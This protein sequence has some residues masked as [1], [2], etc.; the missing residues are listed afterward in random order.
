MSADGFLKATVPANGQNYH[1]TSDVNQELPV[2][3]NNSG[4]GSETPITVSQLFLNTVKKSG[5]KIALLNKDK[6]NK[7]QTWTWQ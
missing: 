4:L 6:D 7:L 3:I 1:W 5:D 2:K